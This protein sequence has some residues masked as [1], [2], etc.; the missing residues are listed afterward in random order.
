MVIFMVDFLRLAE[1]G[2]PPLLLR[3]AVHLKSLAAACVDRLL[4]GIS[5]IAKKSAKK[6]T[7]TSVGSSVSQLIL[8]S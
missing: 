8:S 4:R 5:V 1:S 7:I 6:I 3:Q 2:A